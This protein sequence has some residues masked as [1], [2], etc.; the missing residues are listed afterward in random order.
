MSDETEEYLA[1]TFF[2]T[3]RAGFAPARDWD[4][5]T[6]L[7]SLILPILLLLFTVFFRKGKAKPG[8]GQ[9]TLIWGP[10]GGGKTTLFYLLKDGKLVETQTSMEVNERKVSLGQE[11]VHL[12]DF[13]G[14]NSLH[15]KITPFVENLKRL[16]LVLD[17]TRSAEEGAN[18]LVRLMQQFPV[19]ILKT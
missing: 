14:H 13:P 7:I 19:R 12:V 9:N 3:I 5:A 17:L 15:H 4:D 2:D 10:S 16:V 11:S 6:I 18:M 1:P 8:S